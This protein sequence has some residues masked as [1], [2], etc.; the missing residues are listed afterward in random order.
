MIHLAIRCFHPLQKAKI[1]ILQAILMQFT[2]VSQ[3]S[4]V[5]KCFSQKSFLFLLF[6]SQLSDLYKFPPGESVFKFG[7]VGHLRWS[8]ESG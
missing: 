7:F 6:S 5:V 1:P 4:S 3:F 8:F 2:I